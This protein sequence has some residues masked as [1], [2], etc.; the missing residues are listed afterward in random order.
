MKEKIVVIDWL[1]FVHTA[2]F[3]W[4]NNKE[5]PMTYTLLNMIISCLRRIGIEPLDTIYIATDYLKS[6]RKEY[7]EEYKANRKA[8]RD[9]YEDIDWNKMFKDADD[10]LEKI[11]KGTDWIVIKNEYSEHLEADDI[12]SYIVRNNTDKEIILITIDSDW[13]QFWQFDNVKIFS[14]KSKPKR[15]KIKPKNFNVYQLISSKV[16]QEKSDN[17]IS[18]LITEKDYET[19]LML[20]NLLEL[21]DFID[22]KL[23]LTFKN[24]HKSDDYNSDNIPFKNLRQK[25]EEL[26]ND[27]KDRITYDWCVSL[28]NKRM[29]RKKKKIEK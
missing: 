14:P 10:L 16:K 21:P 12:A 3:N 26:Y 6:W 17:L 8:F 18:P 24:I 25:I 23:E 13:Q 20:I 5:I 19:R 11:D 2:I 27:K 22:K 7:V 1:V 9:S 29:R 15:Y 28:E 4:R